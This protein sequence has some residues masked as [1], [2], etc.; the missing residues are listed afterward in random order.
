MVDSTTIRQ[1]LI[2]AGAGAA[3]SLAVAAMRSFDDRYAPKT[4]TPFKVTPKQFLT[5]RAHVPATLEPAAE[6]ILATLYGMIFGA[7][8]GSFRPNP[9]HANRHGIALGVLVWMLSYLGWLPAIGFTRGV[10]R[11]SIPQLG[12]ALLRHVTYGVVTTNAYAAIRD[13]V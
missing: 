9:T 6:T 10:W 7:L 2:G 4:S 11:W 13:A 3:G 12:G 8:Y 5:Q 1:A